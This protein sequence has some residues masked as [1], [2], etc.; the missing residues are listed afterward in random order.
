MK[1]YNCRNCQN[2]DLKNLFSF[3]NISF[4]GKFPKQDQKI[5]KGALSLVIC[6][7]C[8]LVQLANK[9]NLKY[10]YGPDYGY[11]SSINKTMV[12]HLKKVVTESKKKTKL[13]PKDL[14]LDIAS[15]DGTLLR[16]YNKDVITF[17]IDPLVNK[18]KAFYKKIDYKVSDFFSIRKIKSK[19]KKKFKVITALSVF[20]DL[21]KPNK[22][23][24]D[25]KNILHKDGLFILEF[26]DL[27]SILK[28]K[29]FDT[30]CHEHLEYYSTNVIN[31]MCKKNELKIIDIKSNEINGSSKQFH[32]AHKK[33]I[34]KQNKKVIKS[35][36]KSEKKMK[37][38]SVK[39]LKKF[40]KEINIIK[41]KLLKLLSLIKRN[42]KSIHAYGAST[43]GNVLLQYFGI[44]RNFIDF[45]AERNPNK[46]NLYTPG[47][48][49]K[50]VSERISRNMKPDYYLVLPWHFKKEI[51]KREKKIMKAGSKFIFPLPKLKIY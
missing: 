17:G 38:D 5:K 23:L 42:K 3:G 11:R 49:I 29:M 22:F 18:Y 33:S 36:L 2:R 10:L 40:F 31:E 46:F 13:Q 43:K 26:A 37:L 6:N 19:T 7:K 8:K 39:T 4:T 51:L 12:K 30:I 35:T 47:T 15:N 27:A 21:E 45:V 24:K 20:Y 41:S 50:I 32:I 34:Y 44:G 9:F 48:A 25:V 16:F 14:V 1:I 28:K